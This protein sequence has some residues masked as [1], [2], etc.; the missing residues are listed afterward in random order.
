MDFGVQGV[1]IANAVANYVALLFG[2]CQ[3]LFISR[4]LKWVWE[5]QRE[6]SLTVI[7]DPAKLANFATLNVNIFLRTVCLMCVN[8]DFTAL[9]GVLGSVPLAGDGPVGRLL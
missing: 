4:Q 9:V 6:L 2:L 5:A 8:S 3:I 7:C 1:G